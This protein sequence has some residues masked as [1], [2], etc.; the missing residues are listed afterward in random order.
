MCFWLLLLLENCADGE[1]GAAEG[2]TKIRL[3]DNTL[4]E[5]SIR[6]PK[7]TSA[8]LQER[9]REVQEAAKACPDK[10]A[11]CFGDT[12]ESC[13]LY[14]YDEKLGMESLYEQ[15]PNMRGFA[16]GAKDEYPYKQPSCCRDVGM[17]QEEIPTNLSSTAWL[18]LLLESMPNTDPLTVTIVGD[19]TMTNVSTH[20]FCPDSWKSFTFLAASFFLFALVLDVFEAVDRAERRIPLCA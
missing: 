9:R 20:P 1:F 15:C 14:T 16:E 2:V 18:D 5:A 17:E 8:H 19:S 3:T 6:V 10:P 4:A 12:S 11:D 7:P 13:G